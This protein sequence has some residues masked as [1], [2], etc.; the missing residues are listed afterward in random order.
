MSKPGFGLNWR[1]PLYQEYLFYMLTCQNYN[2]MIRFRRGNGDL[3]RIVLR[4]GIVLETVGDP[5]FCLDIFREIW[6]QKVY[7]R[8]SR[9]LAPRVVVDI[10]AHAGYFAVQA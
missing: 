5:R 4:N 6:Q 2:E 7:L 9:G 10:G 8:F 3:N 1:L